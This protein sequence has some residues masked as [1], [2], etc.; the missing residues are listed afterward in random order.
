MFTTVI[1]QV[2][3]SIGTALLAVILATSHQPGKPPA[4]AFERAFWIATALTALALAPAELLPGAPSP[5]K[6]NNA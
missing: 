4:A 3:G 5:P 6:E 1:R 2:G